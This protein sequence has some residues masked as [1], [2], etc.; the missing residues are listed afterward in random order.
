MSQYHTLYVGGLSPD[1]TEVSCARPARF[2]GRHA[3]PSPPCERAQSDLQGLIASVVPV[4]NFNLKIPTDHVR[5]RRA[6]AAARRR[7][8]ASD[9]ALP[10][11]VNSG[12][13]A[14][15]LL[16]VRQLLQPR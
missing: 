14:V 16:R 4:T 12:D 11:T 5:A 15:A 9:A 1:V 13:E 10:D 7:P 6:A 2:R 3:F 8:G